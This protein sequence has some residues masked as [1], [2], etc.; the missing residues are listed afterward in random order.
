VA[1]Y[2]IYTKSR[3][4]NRVFQGLQQRN[5][6]SFLPKIEVWS[7]RKDRKKKI[8]VPMFSGYLFVDLPDTSAETRLPVLKTPGVVRIL[9][10]PA[11]QEPTAIPDSQIEAI[12]RLVHSRVEILSCLYPR[13]GERARIMNG[14]FAGIEGVVQQ[15]DY[16]KNLFVVSIDLLQRSVAI[17]LESFQVERI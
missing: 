14:P 10:K 6:E 4:E 3:Y 17:K 11:G 8:H 9:G 13:V 2:A 1:W 12:M 16:K 5:V 7:R 15:T